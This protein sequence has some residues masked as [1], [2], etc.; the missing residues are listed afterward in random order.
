MKSG[1]LVVTGSILVLVLAALAAGYGYATHHMNKLFE[2]TLSE[3]AKGAT[4]S[5]VSFDHVSLN[6][7]SG[8]GSIN[9][10]VIQSSDPSSPVFKVDLVDIEFSPFSLLKG[11]VHIKNVSVGNYDLN[12]V[13]APHG[14]T[15]VILT[16]SA[17]A[18]SKAPAPDLAAMRMIVDQLTF[19]Q[20]NLAAA[21]SVFGAKKTK[22]MALSTIKMAGL[23][24]GGDGISP[25]GLAYQIVQQVTSRAA[26]QFTR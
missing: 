17:L 23:N 25:A 10:L 19:G 15:A 18:F 21:I 2:E 4:G 24:G 9:N 1:K 14:N 7:I 12:L 11:P 26:K 8:S 13:F 5:K 3:T 6:L 22:K 20:G 16:A